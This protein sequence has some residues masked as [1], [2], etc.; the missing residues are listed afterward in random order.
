MQFPP[1]LPVERAYRYHVA[2]LLGGEP[3][4]DAPPVRGRLAPTGGDPQEV[5]HFLPIHARGTQTQ[6]HP[7]G[8]AYRRGIGLVR[9]GMEGEGEHGAAA[10]GERSRFGTVLRSGSLGELLP[11]CDGG[12]HDDAASIY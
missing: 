8:Y 2:I 1:P 4:R 9:S 10:E 5:V 11:H 6:S 3:K 7:T 12:G